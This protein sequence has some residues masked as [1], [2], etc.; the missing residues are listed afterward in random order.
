MT[1]AQK[2]VSRLV[3]YFAIAIGVLLIIIGAIVALF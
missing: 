1:E 2:R 3:G